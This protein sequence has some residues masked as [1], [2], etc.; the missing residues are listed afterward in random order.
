MRD[1]PCTRGGLIFHVEGGGG[2][3][4]VPC[5]VWAEA[6]GYVIRV[7]LSMGGHNFMSQNNLQTLPG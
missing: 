1:T 4:I 7:L 2:G 3:F 5:E 6:Y